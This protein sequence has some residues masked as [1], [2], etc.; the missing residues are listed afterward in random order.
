GIVG[1]R[2]IDGRG[3]PAELFGGPIRL[4]IGPAI[5]SVQTGAALYLQA[6]ERTGPGEW[7]GHSVVL[8]PEPGATRREATRSIIEQEA[9]AFE[10]IIA[11]APEQWT[12]LF[13]PIWEDET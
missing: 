11:R 6:I 8:R 4:P 9:R 1:D 12:T 13:F 10:R 3:S 7:L 2:N 5:L